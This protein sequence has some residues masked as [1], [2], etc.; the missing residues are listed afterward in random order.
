MPTGRPFPSLTHLLAPSAATRPR[1]KLGGTRRGPS[2]KAR[3]LGLRGSIVVFPVILHGLIHI[4]SFGRPSLPCFGMQCA[5]PEH[6]RSTFCRRERPHRRRSRHRPGGAS[7][8]GGLSCRTSRTSCPSASP[9][10]LDGRAHPAGMA[11]LLQGKK[12]ENFSCSREVAC[13][14]LAGKSDCRWTCLRPRRLQRGANFKAWR[15]ADCRVCRGPKTVCEPMC[16]PSA[17]YVPIFCWRVSA[18]SHGRPVRR[19]H[20][21]CC[22]HVCMHAMACMH[23]RMP[24]SSQKGVP[25]SCDPA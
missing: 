20:P 15:R 22:V 25:P 11:V 13:S 7:S 6:I 8:P 1:D 14:G 18:V 5:K 17:C 24:A 2:I 3:L 10:C 4:F 16:M 21:R 12:K 19:S 9:A 23:M